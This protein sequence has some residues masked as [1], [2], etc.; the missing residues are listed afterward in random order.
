MNRLDMSIFTLP[1]GTGNNI[2]TETLKMP[3]VYEKS[4]PALYATGTLFY[5]KA[6]IDH[7]VNLTLNSLVIIC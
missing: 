5:S 1:I 2:A 6:R 4:D 7:C 3:L